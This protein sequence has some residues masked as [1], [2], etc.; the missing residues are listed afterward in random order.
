MICCRVNYTIKN[1]SHPNATV[2]E[3]SEEIKRSIPVIKAEAEKL[4]YHLDI[5]AVAGASA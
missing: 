2:T 4:S 5:M 1:E 3:M